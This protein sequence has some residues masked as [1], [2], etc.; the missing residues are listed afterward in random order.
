MKIRKISIFIALLAMITPIR[1]FLYFEAQELSPSVDAL[2]YTVHSNNRDLHEIRI[3][4]YNGVGAGGYG[5]VAAPRL[6]EWMGCS[7]TMVSG[8]DI[9]NDC[10]N[11]FDVLVWP[12]GHYPAYWEVG[13]EGKSKIQDFI[14][15][16]GGYMGICAGAY[17]AC[18]YIVWMDDP[19]F[20]DP[21]YKVEGD[22][23]NL[24]LLLGVAHGPIFEIVER[25]DP[26]YTMT[27]ININDQTHPITD[28]LPESM[29][30]FYGG[31]PYFQLYKDANVTV[32][33]TYD[34][35]GTPA[36]IA[37]Q[38]G[39]GRVFLIAPHAEFEEDSDRDGAEPIS[40]LADE[41]SDW[42]LLLE[43]MKWLAQASVKKSIQ[44]ATGSGT[45]FL[46]PDSGILETLTAVSEGT[47]TTAGK[48]DLLFPHGF[49]SFTVIGLTEGQTMDITI[50]L[51]LNMPE[52]TQYWICTEET[53][54][55]ILIGDDDGDNEITFS[56]TDGEFGDTDGTLNGVIEN[57]GGPGSESQVSTPT[58]PGFPLEAVIIGALLSTT[59][60]LILRKKRIS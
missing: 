22:E 41:G 16:G 31:G 13:L 15:R 23:L 51:P 58:I 3:A 39:Q 6:L 32:L 40:E 28:S 9:N 11:D 4:F 36:I 29:Q 1:S 35:T 42:P 19:A 38:Y 60:L 44:P 55:Q 48:P 45:V 26:G 24:D 52:G 47:L 18:D 14:S 34:V 21:P 54:Q 33:G 7:V 46:R 30:I 49:F 50:T 2:S 56:L 20:P 53:W 8:D 37:F 43:A 5:K 10:L 25:P 12:G 57:L 27:K 17:Y 59:I